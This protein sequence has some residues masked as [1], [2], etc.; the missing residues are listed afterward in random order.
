LLAVSRA[1]GD[2]AF[3]EDR[4]N[5]GLVI[6]LPEVYTEVVTPQ[7]EFCILASDGLWDVTDPQTAVNFVRGHMSKHISAE[8]IVQELVDDAIDQGSI[9]NVT[10]IILFFNLNKNSHMSKPY[11]QTINSISS[12]DGEII[13]D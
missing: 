12:L 6:A 5:S 11:L 13:D 9:D 1:Y 7:T 2:V 10:A 8:T 4:H 3:K